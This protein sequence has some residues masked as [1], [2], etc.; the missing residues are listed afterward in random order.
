MYLRACWYITG[1]L[2][3]FPELCGWYQ[4]S[5]AGVVQ[6]EARNGHLKQND[7]EH[8]EHLFQSKL[9]ARY[10]RSAGPIRPTLCTFATSLLA[11]LACDYV[12]S[13]KHTRS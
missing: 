12:V 9:P 3:G 7:D 13:C 2:D 1:N 8:D 6:C 10:G 4:A 5:I 11:Q